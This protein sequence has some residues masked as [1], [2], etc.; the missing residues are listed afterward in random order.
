MS[1]YDVDMNVRIVVPTGGISSHTRDRFIESRASPSK[2]LATWTIDI[3]VV[4][5]T[6]ID[7]CLERCLD[8]ISQLKI[9]PWWEPGWKTAAWVTISSRGEFTG[10]AL[11]R[12]LCKRAG[13]LEVDV[14]FSVYS[15]QED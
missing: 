12:K 4:P 2:D 9:Q 8:A 15:H 7:E 6:E 5:G 3:D 13:E 14:V 10:I 11:P 1:T